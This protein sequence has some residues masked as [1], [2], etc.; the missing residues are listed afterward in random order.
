MFSMEG[1]LC[2]VILCKG[3]NFWDLKNFMGVVVDEEG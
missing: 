1:V 3:W 2:K